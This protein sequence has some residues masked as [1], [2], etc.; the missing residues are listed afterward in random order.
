M[1]PRIKKTED[2]RIVHAERRQGAAA[3]ELACCLPLLATLLLGILELG[4]MIEVQQ[5]LSNAARDGARLAA[6]GITIDSSTA[7]E[8]DVHATDVTNAVAGYLK[9]NG[10]NTTGLVVQF[11]DLTSPSI[12][13][14]YLCQRLDHLRVAVQLPSSNVRWTLTS[15]VANTNQAMF[16]ASSDWFSL[17]DSNV[18]VPTILPTN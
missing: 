11:S 18:S 4:R 6:A 12:T 3:V 14:P 16:T 5:L 8:V 7:S 2:R 1:S 15:F 10:I 17:R 9:L 13:E